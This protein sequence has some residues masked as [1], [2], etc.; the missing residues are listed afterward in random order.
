MHTR[1]T[2]LLS[3]QIPKHDNKTIYRASKFKL[4]LG[5]NVLD[6]KTL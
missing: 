3:K 1:S 5:E 4:Q 2:K 6:I